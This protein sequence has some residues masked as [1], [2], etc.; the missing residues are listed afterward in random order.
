[1]RRDLGLD[2]GGTALKWAVVADGRVA[3]HGHVP[4]PRGGP[5]AVVD[6]MVEIAGQAGAVDSAGVGVPGLYE[7]DGSTGL[8][9]NV[10][11]EW[12][13]YPLAATLGGRLGVPVAV[14]NDARAFTLAELRLGAGR[15]C[16]DL[17]AVTLGTGVGGGVVSDGRVHLGARHRAGE[18]G[19]VVV[20]PD[21]LP[22]GCGSRGCL[23]TVASAP[24]IVAAAARVVWQGLAS[25]LADACD[26]EPGKLDVPTV[27]AVAGAGD[28]VAGEVLEGAARALGA[29]LASA[30]TLLAPERI[31]VGGGVSGALDLL[32]PT[33][34]E[35]IRT[36][37][38]LSD[39]PPVLAAELGPRAGAIGAALW[40]RDTEEH[41]A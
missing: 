4:T 14:C 27:A 12:T 7:P 37:V 26:G 33:I 34:H 23:E 28:R 5:A 10:P 41:T 13:A 16:R 24:A 15:G 2:L 39:P 21:G 25:E 29:A 8:L 36:R 38:R 9:P 11:G 32:R 35:A 6:A 31:V 40:G 19:H 1:M 18:L 30:C 22:C 3:D 17:V 20:A